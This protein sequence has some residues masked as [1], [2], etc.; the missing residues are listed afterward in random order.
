[1]PRILQMFKYFLYFPC[2]NI[3][4]ATLGDWWGFVLVCVFVHGVV[5]LEVTVKNF[6]L[7]SSIWELNWVCKGWAL[8]IFLVTNT[9]YLK[10]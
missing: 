5:I 4:T 8:N 6:N 3:L 10:L 7:H 1:M 9:S 2:V